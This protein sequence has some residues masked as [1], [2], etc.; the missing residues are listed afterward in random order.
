SAAGMLDDSIKNLDQLKATFGAT[1]ADALKQLETS[2]LAYRTTLQNFRTS[3]GDIAQARKEMTAQGQDIVKLSEAMYQLQ[4][5]RRDAESAQARNMQ[6]GCTP[7]AMILGITAAVI[8][9]RQITRPL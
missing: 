2:L 5:D 4:L 9:T 3:S 6:I 1:H 8:I 7:L